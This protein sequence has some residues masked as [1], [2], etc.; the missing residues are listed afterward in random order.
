[1]TQTAPD[2]FPTRHLPRVSVRDLPE[3][4]T[5]AWPVIGPGVIA[6]G[7]GLASGEFILFPY[8]ASQVG[9]VFL[10]AAAVGI[11]TQWFLNMEIERYTLATGETA[12][13]GF[14]RFWRHWGLVFALMVYF[15][16]L[17]P[18]WASSS[19]TMVTYLFGGDAT[20][21]AIGMLVVIGLTLTLAPVI[22][23]ALERVE[24]VKVGLVVVFLV[25]A[26]IFAVSA[27]AWRALPD[28]VTAPEFPTELG[29][30]LILSALVF[31][32][33]GGGQ[34]LVQSNWIRDKG[35]G[36]GRYV[37][38]LVSPVTGRPEA[39]PD[40]AGFVFEPTEE[41]L[42]RW[43]RWWRLANREQLV[44]FVLI[45]FVTIV[46]MSMLAYSTVYGTPGLANSV[47][48]LKVEGERLGDSVGPWFGTLFWVIG[49]VSLFAAAMGIV[50]YTSRLAADVL[51]TSYLRRHSESRIYFVLVW[52][53]VGLGCAILLAGFDQPLPLLVVSACVGGLMMFIYSILLLVLNR[54]VLPPQIRPRSFRVAALVWAVL[55][56]GVFSALTIWQQGERL[57][58]WLR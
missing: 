6:A 16:N 52:G 3:P 18:G 5:S 21:I 7:V 30:A 31:A 27:D 38:R 58:D 50:D 46:L 57:L 34:N 19:A 4:P 32:G 44:T 39:A 55:L 12:L 53:L 15:A 10:W 14:S 51:K 36:M 43:R 41:N 47:S 56:F 17:W 23:T 25:V 49:A 35:F 45:S 42:G 33:A 28:T 11:V 9:L 48:F 24:F 2:R 13:T 20:W 29:F 1:M 26:V 54:R 22:Y 37:P 8:I 40:A